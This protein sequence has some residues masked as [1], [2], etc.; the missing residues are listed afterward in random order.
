MKGKLERCRIAHPPPLPGGARFEHLDIGYRRWGQLSANGDNAVLVCPALTGDSD[1]E[2]WWPALLGPGRALDPEQDFIICADV[3]GGS[4]QTTSPTSPAPDRRAWGERFPEI[5][6]RDMVQVQRLL[7]EQLGVA[8]LKLVIGGSLGGMQALEWAVGNSSDVEAA[9]AIAAPARQS[10][11]ARAFNHIQRRALERHGDIE[12]ARMI[13]MISYRHWDNL[14]SRFHANHQA[15]HPVEAW[16]DHHG[17]ALKSRFDPVSYQRLMAAM[18][19]HDVGVG[20]GGWQQALSQ[21]KVPIQ[22]IGI[23]SDLLYPPQAQLDLA[24]GLPGARLAWLEAPQGHDAF[25]IEQDQL[26][27]L[28]AEFRRQRDPPGCPAGSRVMSMSQRLARP[29]GCC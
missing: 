3:L 2:A 29:S 12:L 16:L 24:Q 22:I 23:S 5:S 14:D 7:L 10:A 28:V 26:N 20:R 9:V 13:A 11:W 25:L 8:R 1:L 19:R 15:P 27:R 6:V 21:L 18:D 4:G 17:Q